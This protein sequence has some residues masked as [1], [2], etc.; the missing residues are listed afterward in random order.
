MNNRLSVKEKLAHSGRKLAQWYG[1]NRRFLRDSASRYARYP[2]DLDY[3]TIEAEIYRDYAPVFV[4]ST[5]RCGTEFLTVVLEASKDLA[6]YHTQR[7]ELKHYK[8][9]A[10][11]ANRTDPKALREIIKACRFESICDEYLRRRTYVETNNAITF[12]A[13]QLATLFPRS[14]FIHLIRDPAAFA[15][16]GMRR[17][18]Y[19][20]RVES[21]IGILRNLDD[22]NWESYDR[23]TKI[24]W[25]WNET[26][27]FIQDVSSTI[28][29]NR[30][31]VLRSED[32]FSGTET[33]VE[34]FSFLGAQPPP[35]RKLKK[36]T[37]KKVN[38]QILGEFPPYK[39][40]TPEQKAS[41]RRF[42]SLHEA[43]GYKLS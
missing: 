17:G 40:W 16:S 19:S 5:G 36:V 23:L 10:Y 27:R 42:V 34:I 15:R 35:V 11:R 6:V 30:F 37:S 25:L 12:F 26:N 9:E 14:K 21:D 13:P 24:G 32:L 41:L 1:I 33:A 2:L 28:E 7:P 20:G 22:A 38:E 29:A 39:Q 43:Y 31:L 4:L 18:W 3:S 8:L